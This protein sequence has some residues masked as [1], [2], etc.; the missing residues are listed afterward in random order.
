MRRRMCSRWFARVVASGLVGLGG[1]AGAVSPAAA[2]PGCDIHP[3][4]FYAQCETGAVNSETRPVVPPVPLP[5]PIGG[6]GKPP[7]LTVT[8]PGYSGGSAGTGGVFTGAVTPGGVGFGLGC[9]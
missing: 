9:L 1:L 4:D 3:E 2:D 5:P 7:C 8:T 6:P